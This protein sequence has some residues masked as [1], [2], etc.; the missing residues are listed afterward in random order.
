VHRDS[1][2][3]ALR[4]SGS[5]IRQGMA[6]GQEVANAVTYDFALGGDHPFSKLFQN[7]FGSI[8]ARYL[9]AGV[10]CFSAFGSPQFDFHSE[11]SPCPEWPLLRTARPI[12][13]RRP[14]TNACWVSARAAN[15]FKSIP[16]NRT[17]RAAISSSTRQRANFP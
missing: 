12:S 8:L 7:K 14:S 4:P 10:C 11:V 2:G 13:N 1:A 15:R 16:R 3:I 9:C 17:S 6:S 5:S